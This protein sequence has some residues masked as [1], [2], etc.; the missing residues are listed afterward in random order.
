M[1]GGVLLGGPHIEHPAQALRVTSLSQ[2]VSPGS[3]VA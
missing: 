3:T 2:R 1:A